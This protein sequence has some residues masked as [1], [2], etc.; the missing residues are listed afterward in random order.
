MSAEMRWCE[1]FRF[2]AKR[3]SMRRIQIWYNISYFS[4]GLMDLS[5]WTHGA[6]H[7][8]HRSRLALSIREIRSAI[9]CRLSLYYF[10]D[11]PQILPITMFQSKI[12]TSLPD[13]SYIWNEMSLMHIAALI[14]VQIS[15]GFRGHLVEIR[16][17]ATE[18]TKEMKLAW[19]WMGFLTRVLGRRQEV[20]SSGQAM[21]R[22]LSWCQCS[23]QTWLPNLRQPLMHWTRSALNFV[24][25]AMYVSHTGQTLNYMAAALARLDLPKNVFQNSR[26]VFKGT[27]ERHCNFPK[28]HVMT[29][30]VANVCLYDSAVAR[31]VQDG[32]WRVKN[33]D[34]MRDCVLAM[35]M[36]TFASPRARCMAWL[37]LGHSIEHQAGQCSRIM[38]MVF[39]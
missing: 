26:F 1:D 13:L 31:G 24:T 17:A 38:C 14:F 6:L 7:P 2:C 23:P 19:D 16:K 36:L 29:H 8:R 28:L 35:Y 3:K 9:F 32:N 21:N 30:Y 22:K 5:K 34:T 12:F 18:I 25:L 10:S 27:V 39:C 11:L 20:Y 15:L 37:N 33:S 4:V